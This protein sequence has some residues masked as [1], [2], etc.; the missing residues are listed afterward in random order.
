MPQTV[1]KLNAYLPR[2][3]TKFRRIASVGAV[4][5]FVALHSSSFAQPGPSNKAALQAQAQRSLELNEKGVMAIKMRDFERA[6][7]LFAEALSIDSKNIT[8]VFNLAGMYI[9]NKKESLAVALLEKYSSDFPKDAGLQARLGDAYFSS[10]NPES[11]RVAYEQAYKLD[12]NYPTLPVRL[13]T[14]Y[15]MTKKLDK[16]VAMYEKAVKLNPKDFQ[17]LRNLSSL[18]VALNKP[19]Q[20]ISTAKRA[21]QISSSPDLYVTL[22]TAYQDVRDPKN[23]LI[24]FRRAEEMGHKDPALSKIIEDLAKATGEK[25]RA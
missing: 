2:Y 6:E 14:V 11:A 20:A 5:L 22:G 25:K 17:S 18:Y 24:A 19:H 23:A 9:T 4:V 12:P 8:A 13:A 10:Q 3:T 15:S 21:L 1:V 7:T 16:A